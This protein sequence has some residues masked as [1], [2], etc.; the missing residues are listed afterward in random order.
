MDFHLTPLEITN[1]SEAGEIRDQVIL[2]SH[3]PIQFFEYGVYMEKHKIPF[4]K[5]CKI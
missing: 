4:Q 2:S 3:S 5:H 1:E